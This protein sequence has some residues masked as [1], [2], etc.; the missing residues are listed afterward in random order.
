MEQRNFLVG[1][2]LMFLLGVGFGIVNFKKTITD[3][4]EYRTTDTL[5]IQKNQQG[6]HTTSP[7]APR[8]KPKEFNLMFSDT[9]AKAFIEKYA[10]IAIEEHRI[11]K[12]PASITLSQ[13]L[14]ES[15]AETSILSRRTK[16]YFGMKCFLK[17]CKKGHCINF[18][19][20]THKDFFIVYQTPWLSFRDHSK[21]LKKPRYRDCYKCGNNTE[22]WSIELKKAGYAT[23]P[24]Y[25][26]LL[27]YVIYKYNLKN[28]DK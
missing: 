2:F 17:S 18:T 25:S 6:E 23:M 27:Q 24:E 26:E 10:T 22:C 13:G 28:Y 19:D 1:T 5:I 7:I 21:L 15:A 8:A 16:N 9:E 12:I 4:V 3:V 14:V 11:N 20:D